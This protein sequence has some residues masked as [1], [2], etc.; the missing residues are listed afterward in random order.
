VAF[1]ETSDL[2]SIDL[3]GVIPLIVKG[4]I[5]EAIPCQ[6]LKDCW[7]MQQQAS[8]FIAVLDFQEHD[9]PPVYQIAIPDLHAPSLDFSYETMAA[10]LVPN[11]F[12]AKIRLD[13]VGTH[14]V[15]LLR[16]NEH[17]DASPFLVVVTSRTCPGNHFQADS[18]GNCACSGSAV[19]LRGDCVRLAHLIFVLCSAAIGA[20][21][22]VLALAKNQDIRR[23]DAK[24]M[25]ALKDMELVAQAQCLGSGQHLHCAPRFSCKLIPVASLP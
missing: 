15:F 1:P 22:L 21:L 8:I 3:E 9:E 19:T 2:L 7:T 25:I 10:G 24:W 23:R 20:G 18:Q 14:S 12:F 6:R 5:R 13:T 16:N 17:V 4:D 11:S